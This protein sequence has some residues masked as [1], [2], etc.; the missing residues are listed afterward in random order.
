MKVNDIIT[1]GTYP[2]TKYKDEVSPLEWKV[3]AVEDGKALGYVQAYYGMEEI[4]PAVSG[5]VVATL[6]RQ[7]ED[8]AKGEIIAFVQE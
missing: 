1:F 5:R 7:G 3:L 6:G 2:Q 4:I 8:V